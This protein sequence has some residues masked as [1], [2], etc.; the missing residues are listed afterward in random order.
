VTG[1]HIWEVFFLVEVGRGRATSAISA[2]E[3][4]EV[5]HFLFDASR[6][7]YIVR[8]VEAPFFRPVVLARRDGCL[9]PDGALYTQLAGRL[10][11]L[12]GPAD[13]VPSAHTAA[14]RDG[15][16][17]MFISSTGDAYPAGFLPLSLGNV[18][19]LPLRDI[20]TGSPLL[21][22][23]RAARFAGR[24]GRCGYADLC[25][26]SRARAYAATGDPLGE[27]PACAYRP[28]IRLAG[29]V[30]AAGARGARGLPALGKPAGPLAQTSRRG[31]YGTPIF[32]QRRP[33][34]PGSAG[35]A[36][37]RLR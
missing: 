22:D 1:A 5:C 13:R 14:T 17:I 7:G 30:R 35:L 2:T 33:L 25:G 37:R 29:A 26:G 10:R 12:L 31:Q 20:Y 16:G 8:T 21:R 28:H 24:C 11:E 15:K 32:R 18:R 6:Y 34:V 27:D 36:G 19:R 23:I 4:D 9:P 3:H